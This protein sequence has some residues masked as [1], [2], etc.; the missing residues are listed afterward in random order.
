AHPYLYARVIGLFHV[1]AYLAGCDPLDADDTEPR[2][3]QVLWLRWFDVD[4]CA[5]G[6]KLRRLPRLKWAST[7]DEAFGFIAPRQVLRAAHLIPAFHYGQSDAA[8]PGS[9]IARQEEEN[10]IDWTYHYVGIFADRDMLMRHVGDGV[11]HQ[12]T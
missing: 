7:G 5:P 11:G 3:F 12:N 6:I 8:L 2:P 10:D 9:S 4:L 1:H